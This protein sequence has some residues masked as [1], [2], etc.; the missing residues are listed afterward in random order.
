MRNIHTFSSILILTLTLTLILT[1]ATPLGLTHPRDN[2]DICQNA[3]IT[4]CTL[5]V[6]TTASA[7]KVKPYVD[8]TWCWSKAKTSGGQWS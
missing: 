7:L 6:A 3:P 1:T 2:V 5:G 4:F 8:Y